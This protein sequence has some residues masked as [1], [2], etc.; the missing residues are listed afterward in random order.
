MTKG[1]TKQSQVDA[2][3]NEYNA[4]GSMISTLNQTSLMTTATMAPESSNFADPQ[5]QKAVD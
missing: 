1:L 2:D 5:W 4:S 3:V